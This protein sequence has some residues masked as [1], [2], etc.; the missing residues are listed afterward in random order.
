MAEHLK[1]ELAAELDRARAKLA[2]NF[3]AFRRDIDVPAQ[4][5]KSIR[6][7]K[8][9]W[10]GAAAAIGLLLAKIPA[11][12]KK[13]YVDRHTNERVKKIEKA[14]LALAVGKMLFSAA[15][16]FLTSFATKKMGEF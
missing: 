2:R 5:K 16:P 11:R 13:I 6:E 1:L 15:R 14:G 9:A 10:L 7:N 4:L 3:D 12:K 8:G